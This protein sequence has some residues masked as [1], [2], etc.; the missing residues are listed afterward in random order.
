VRRRVAAVVALP[1]PL[2]LMLVLVLAVVVLCVMVSGESVR[3]RRVLRV[4]AMLLLR[5][6]L[7]MQRGAIR[8]VAVVVMVVRPSAT[9]RV[10]RLRLLCLQRLLH[11]GVCPILLGARGHRAA[12]RAAS[13]EAAA[14][15]AVEL[16]EPVDGGCGRWHFHRRSG[17]HRR[18][19]CNGRR[20]RL[21]RHGAGIQHGHGFVPRL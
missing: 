1:V 2:L 17:L 16:R 13:D 18:D 15:V 9:G 20:R 6:L 10:L 21:V 4:P 14:G 7:R 19:N 5:R 12:A 8:L 11:D 3:S